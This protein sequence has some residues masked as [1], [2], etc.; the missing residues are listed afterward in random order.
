M[1]DGAKLGSSVQTAVRIVQTGT[2]EDD[3]K[4]FISTIWSH[5]VFV[6]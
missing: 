1:V 4:H 2:D 6:Q 3:P 5:L